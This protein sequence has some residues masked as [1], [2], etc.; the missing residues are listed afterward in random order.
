MIPP[1]LKLAWINL[2]EQN[3]EENNEAGNEIAGSFAEGE[4]L[5]EL[6]AEIAAVLGW[7]APSK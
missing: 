3:K 7:L 6:E 4:T 1:V 2:L 5:E